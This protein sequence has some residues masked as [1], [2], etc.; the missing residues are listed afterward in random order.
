MK[1]IEDIK[2]IS[3]TMGLE[4][5]PENLEEIAKVRLENPE[6]PLKELGTYLRNPV[7]KSGVNHRLRKLSEIAEELRGNKE[8]KL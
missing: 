8:E 2:Y 4:N 7:G 5:L 1:Q 6:A 3:D